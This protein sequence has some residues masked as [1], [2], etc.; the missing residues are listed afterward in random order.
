MLVVCVT[1]AQSTEASITEKAT[2]LEQ[3]AANL[4]GSIKQQALRKDQLLVERLDIILPGLMKREN[5]DMWLIVSREYNEDPILKTLLPADWLHARRR[6]M[7]AFIRDPLQPEN[8][9]TYSLGRYDVGEFYQNVWDANEHSSQFAALVALIARFNVGSIAINQS[10]H[11][12]LADGLVVTDKQLLLANL[13]KEMQKKLVSAQPLAVS[14]LETR[15]ASEIKHYQNLVQL[16]KAIINTAFSSQ[17]IKPGVTTTEDIVWW[18]RQTV[19]DYGLTTWFQPSVS[20]QRKDKDNAETVIGHGDLL[21]VDFGISYLG[22]NTDIQQ[23]AYV[24][25]PGEKDAPQGLK[26]ALAQGNQLQALLTNSFKTGVTGNQLLQSVRAKAVALGLKPS[27]YSHPIGPYGH[28]AGTS[29]GMW[30]N[31]SF[32][33]GSGE[34]PLH[35]N[36]AYAIELNVTSY[37][38]EWQREIRIM[39]EEDAWF[40]GEKV[41][42]LY[43][44]QEQLI[45]IE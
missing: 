43:P 23:H 21:H 10:E 34:W 44:R 8:V 30:D 3:L 11:I 28:N 6:T 12:G 36:T 26:Q 29:I 40:D 13:P 31:Q 38:P 9:H 22:L 4:V 41:E 35:A 45:L 1:K 5:I 18:L 39:L 7:L 20:L 15:T 24:L 2:E 33:P 37:I 19:N 27:I 25:A 32:L 42:Y 16:T 17:V 14:W